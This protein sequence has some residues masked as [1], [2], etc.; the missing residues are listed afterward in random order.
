MRN[1]FIAV[2]LYAAV[3]WLCLMHFPVDD[4]EGD[5]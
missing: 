5:E 1:L 3:L 4:G 2:A